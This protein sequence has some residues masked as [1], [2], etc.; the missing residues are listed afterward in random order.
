MKK[1]IAL[2]FALAFSL[3]LSACGG[4]NASRDGGEAVVRIGVFGPDAGQELLG[5]RY[6]NRETPR[7]SIGGT[8][9]TVELVFAGDGGADGDADLTPAEALAER[10]VAA[11][12]DARGAVE[13]T[14]A[15]GAAGIPVIGVL[16]TDPDATASGDYYFRICFPDS[17][18]GD[19]LAGF[20][21]GRISAKTAYCL[22][23]NGSAYDQ[24]LIAGFS[25]AFEAAGGRIIADLFPS[26][27]E[28]FSFYLN[29]AGE[30]GADV[31]FLPVSVVYAA[32]ILSQ[33]STLGV[34]ASFLGPDALDDGR[35]PGVVKGS[36]I[37]LYVSAA[38]QEGGNADF[39]EGFKEYLGSDG[40]ALAA[41]G[42]D[43]AVSAAAA[44][45]Y[46]AYRV[47]LEAMRRSGS[48]HRADI[49][50]VLPGVACQGVSGDIAFGDSGDALRGNVYI[51][52]ADRGAWTL[53][54]VR[55]VG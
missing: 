11:V 6:A 28:D 49:M 12:L 19:A 26:N 21:A 17:L 38:Y 3:M 24:S 16:C 25:R 41:N 47:V 10:D 36:G 32:Q 48:A 40:A 42:G 51:K 8:E 33:A 52:T 4:G 27:T 34:A 31:I 14:V 15:F 45:G 55:S 2:C 35:L 54:S 1:R 44:L 53:E 20:A 37:R 43:D 13:D 9:Y 29:R 23:E 46:D 39:D 18:Q 22:G 7:I 30:E 5:I 50:A